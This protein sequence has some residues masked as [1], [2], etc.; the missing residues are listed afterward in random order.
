MYFMHVMGAENTTTN[1][2]IF[3]HHITSSKTITKHNI[4]KHCVIDFNIDS[5][6]KLYY[7]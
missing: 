6:L 4:N 5:V 7:S 2:Y 1:V 3:L